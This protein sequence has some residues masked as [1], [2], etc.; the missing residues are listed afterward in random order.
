MKG[1]LIKEGSTVFQWETGVGTRKEY[2]GNPPK[3]HQSRRERR[4][5]GKGVT[6]EPEKALGYRENT[7]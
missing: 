7:K 4:K 1:K 3:I 5:G 2:F 6:W